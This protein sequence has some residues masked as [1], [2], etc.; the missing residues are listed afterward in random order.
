MNNIEKIKPL[1]VFQKD[2]FYYAQIIQRQKDNSQLKIDMK[3]YRKFIESEKI[4]EDN[5][6]NIKD[7]CNFYNARCY[8]SLNPRSLE[9]LGKCCLDEFVNRIKN[10]QYN[11]IYRIPDKLALSPDIIKTKN[12]VESQR[13][14]VD[15]DEEKDVEP[16]RTFIKSNNINILAELESP[17]GL[18]LVVSAF[19][20]KKIIEPYQMTNAKDDYKIGDSTF[21]LRPECNVILYSKL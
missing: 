18:H 16:I 12:V 6:E 20:K 7:L 17:H 11:N 15:I 4:F 9:K 1:L 10:N 8:I 13:W 3:R 5:I 19:N 14:L 21:T 2:I